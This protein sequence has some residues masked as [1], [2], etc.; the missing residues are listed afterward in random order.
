[1]ELLDLV[2]EINRYCEAKGLDSLKTTVSELTSEM[3][4]DATEMV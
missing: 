2:I 3:A 4:I 1:M